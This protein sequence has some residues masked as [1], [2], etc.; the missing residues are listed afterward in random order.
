MVALWNLIAKQVKITPRL[1]ARN[2]PINIHLSFGIFCSIYYSIYYSIFMPDM[3]TG[4][5]TPFC[6]RV[7]LISFTLFDHLLIYKLHRNYLNYINLYPLAFV[8][9]IHVNLPFLLVCFVLLCSIIIT[10]FSS[11]NFKMKHIYKNSTNHQRIELNHLVYVC[12]Y[13]L[14]NAALQIRD[15]DGPRS[16]WSLRQRGVSG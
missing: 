1:T 13:D 11:C 3:V 7:F 15:S 4:R 14:M 16:M 5:R 6:K 10:I 12:S 8:L 9:L 2:I